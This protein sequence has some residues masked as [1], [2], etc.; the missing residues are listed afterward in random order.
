MLQYPK[1][2]RLILAS[3]LLM[4]EGMQSPRCLRPLHGDVSTGRTQSQAAISLQVTSHHILQG[5]VSCKCSE[6]RGLDLPRVIVGCIAL[7]DL[8]ETFE[9]KH[10]KGIDWSVIFDLVEYVRQPMMIWFHLVGV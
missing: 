8:V 5:N 10:P 6:E 7:K 4:H 2:H 1:C 3:V 9:Q